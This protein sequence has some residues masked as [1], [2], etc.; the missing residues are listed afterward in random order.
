MLVWV[1]ISECGCGEVQKSV[2]AV[3]FVPRNFRGFRQLHKLSCSE[4]AHKPTELEKD[5]QI[6]N[7]KM[8]GG[9]DGVFVLKM[10][11]P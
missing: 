11:P 8:K 2:G 6:T 1:W 7:G 5:R 10:S 9:H 4:L 3:A